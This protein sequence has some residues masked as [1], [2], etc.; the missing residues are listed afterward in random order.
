[1]LVG[2]ALVALM[3][4]RPLFAT[5]EDAL[6]H[7]GAGMKL[8]ELQRL[9]EAAREFELALV[10]NPNLHDARYHLAVCFFR[11]KRFPEARE[12][13]KRLASENFKKD[14]VCYYLARLDLVDGDLD[15][16]IA[17]FQSLRRDEPLFD[18]LYYLGFAHLKKGEANEAV[19]FL[20]RQLD[21]NPRDF[22][23]HDQLA[24]AFVKLGRVADSEREF[25]ESRHLH[26]YYR[27]G[28][29]EMMDCRTQLRDGKADEAWAACGAAL[30]SDDI[31]KLVAVGM[32]FGE[33]SQFDRARQLFTRA[34]ELDPESPE[35]NYDLGL[36]YFRNKNYVQARKYLQAAVRTRPNFF[37]AVALYGTV[38]Y[39]LRED[40][41]ALDALRRARD[42]R[43][44]DQAVRNML[45]E[46]ERARP[47]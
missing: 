31:D 45:A 30:G 13:F 38:L 10:S 41:P 46:L 21:F 39:L 17:G 16:A 42:L 44:E 25:E 11:Q 15:S 7:L 18:E 24:R 28:K 36:T 33:F 2:F 35:A 22:R 9:A 23:A 5:A 8:Y 47:R 4:V 3:G 6:A 34:L 14:W 12:Q 20:K 27:E 29:K 1:M 37:A 32:L 26:D 43:P 40:A 19:E